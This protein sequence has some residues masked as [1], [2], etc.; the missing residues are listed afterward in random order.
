MGKKTTKQVGRVKQACHLEQTP[1][2]CIGVARQK[3]GVAHWRG[4]PAPEFTWACHLTTKAWHAKPIRP[5]IEW[6]CHLSNKAWHASE[7][8]DNAKAGRATWY[9][10]H[11]TP[12]QEVP[13][14]RAT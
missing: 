10:R 3:L 4:T 6:A 7:Q 12:A 13:L 1:Q 11:G 14:R 8:G 5:T 9:R 2:R